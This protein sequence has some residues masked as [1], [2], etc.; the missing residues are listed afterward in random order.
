MDQISKISIKNWAEYDKPRDK[1]LHKGPS[2]L[3]NAELIAILIGSG[4]LS[5]SAVEL[6]KRI[7][8]DVKDNFA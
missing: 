8:N 7:M 6:S 1:I 2:A 5:E 4:N 3:S